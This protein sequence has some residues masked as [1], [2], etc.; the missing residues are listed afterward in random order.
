MI[1][2]DSDSIGDTYSAASLSIIAIL[3][4]SIAKNPGNRLAAKCDFSKQHAY[5]MVGECVVGLPDFV[6]SS[7]DTV[8]LSITVKLLNARFGKVGVIP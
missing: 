5:I 7:F 1:A 4:D 2:N 6:C 8:R 3:F